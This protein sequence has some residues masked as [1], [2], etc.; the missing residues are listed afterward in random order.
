MYI[1][2]FAPGFQLAELQ[3]LT[4]PVTVAEEGTSVTDKKVMAPVYRAIR[5]ARV[6]KAEGSYKLCTK[7]LCSYKLCYNMYK[8]DQSFMLLSTVFNSYVRFKKNLLLKMIRNLAFLKCSPH[9]IAQP[10]PAFS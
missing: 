5:I 1:G 3:D 8:M 10:A 9:S 7:K 2:I 4:D 6:E